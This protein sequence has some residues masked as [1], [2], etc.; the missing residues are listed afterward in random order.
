MGSDF[1]VSSDSGFNESA[2]SDE[3]IRPR[4]LVCA[5][6]FG[7]ASPSGN[8]EMKA[9]KKV[10]P[11]ENLDNEKKMQPSNKSEKTDYSVV[12]EVSWENSKKNS[13]QKEHNLIKC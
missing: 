9:R 2:S 7:A 4:R 8:D 12:L 10:K 1:N 5:A 3:P 13:H 6:R 11:E